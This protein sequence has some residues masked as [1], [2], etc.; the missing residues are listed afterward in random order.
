MLFWLIAYRLLNDVE[1]VH[2]HRGRTSCRATVTP[3]R[4]CRGR[5][6]NEYPSQYRSS[7]GQSAWQ[8]RSSLSITSLQTANVSERHTRAVREVISQAEGA[9]VIRRD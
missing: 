4:R 2:W 3:P 6:H 1:D 5:R 9:R 7:Y 8:P